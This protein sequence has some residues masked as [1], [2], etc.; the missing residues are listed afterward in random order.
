MP[1]SSIVAP[2]ACTANVGLDGHGTGQRGR[3]GGG[4]LFEIGHRD[5]FVNLFSCPKEFATNHTLSFSLRGHQEKGTAMKH[6]DNKC[7]NLYLSLLP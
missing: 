4:R 2:C 6:V 7:V 1:G 5:G 3:G